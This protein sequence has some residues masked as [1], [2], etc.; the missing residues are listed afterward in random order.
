MNLLNPNL[1]RLVFCWSVAIGLLTIALVQRT[2]NAE[3][4]VDDS[5]TSKTRPNIILVMTD[6]QG[7]GDLSCHG[8]PFLKTPHI[9]KL[10]SQST[11]FTDFHVS[12]T[13][14]P[15]RAALMS[16]KAP[17]KVGV[18]H[19]VV[20]RE[21][22]TLETTTIADVLRSAGYA[23]G[24][25]GK[26]HLG[27]ADPYQPDRRG[28]D[29][30]F[31]HG[32]GGIGQSHAGD[33]SDAPGTNYF[34]PIIKHNG[35]FEQTRGY[36]TD[37]FF[38][39][40]LGW[41]QSK[42]KSS[43]AE[44]PETD[45]PFFAYISTNAPHSPYRVDPSYSDLFKE[46]CDPQQAAFLGMIVNIDENVGLLME[47]L[48]QWNL[49]DNTLLIF[50]TDN[51]SAAGSPIHNAGMKGGKGSMN[52][53]GS[54][55]PLF[56][57]LPGVTKPGVEIDRMT[58]HFD[59]FPTLAEIAGAKIPA[60]LDLDGRSLVP[61]IENPRSQ[62][63]PRNTFFHVGRWAK[64]GAPERFSKGDPN[65]DNSKYK[66]FAVRNE[67]WR[68]VNERLF[69]IVDDP[70]EATDIAAKHPEVVESLRTSFD[71]WWDQV[72][73]LMVNENAPLDVPRSFEVQFERQRNSVGIPQWIA[74]DLEGRN[75]R[76]AWW[77]EAKFGM[78]V[79]W[80]IYSTTGGEYKGQKLPNS[81]EWMMARGK[82]PIAEYE[83]YAAQFN[84][85]GFDASEFV[86][87]AK[88]AGMKYIVITAKHHDGFAMFGSDCSEFDVVDATPFKRD[89][90]KEL[91]DEC[92]KQNIKFGFYYSQAQDWH[93]PG[94]HG[95]SWDKS[96]QRVSTD[97]Y[98]RDK[99]VPEVRQLLTDYGPI[100]IFWWDTPRKMSQE[101]FDAL[102][103]LTKLQPSVITNDRLG[104]GYRG[105]Y[106][107][108]ERN[109]P[110]QAPVGEDWEVCMPISG[111]WGY[112]KGDNDFKSAQKLIRNLI[113][114]A[115]KG[116]NY[117]LNVSPTGDGTL[118]PP[119]IQR[120][121]TIGQWMDV[122]GE[123]IYATV[124][125]P[126]PQLDWGRCTAKI[127]DGQTTLY[128][129][130]FDW[131][132]DGKLI[133]P[134]LTQKLLSARLLDGKHDVA[135]AVTDAGLEL[136]LTG[137]APDPNASVIKLTIDGELMVKVQLPTPD[138]SGKLVLTADTAYV[139]NNE[140][141]KQADVRH[142]DDIPH[143]GYWLDNHAWVDWNIQ[144]DQPGTYEVHATMSVQ[145]EETRFFF[146]SE[147]NMKA[148]KVSST[149]SYGKYEQNRLGAI[150]IDQA[151]RLNLIIKPDPENWQPM[152]L[153]Q[154][155][156]QR[157]D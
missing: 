138:A 45:Q 142:H 76:L 137:E 71:A 57:R 125:S 54:R 134:G 13:C 118:L 122:N 67:Q 39:Q 77:R 102:H 150:T 72:R 66:G 4:P 75:E 3:S 114:I 133:V 18:T 92:Q 1:G 129:H 27:D 115:S 144:I 14:S 33:Q 51:G 100:G 111:S 61:L 98:V 99:A 84:P 79:H 94:G 12:A 19:T 121:Q 135:S 132:E 147:G 30:V 108:F 56:M 153:R 38:Q 112:K 123:S 90:M 52:E 73:P 29:E 124:A 9:D 145:N 148:A 103:S 93:H 89:I 136:T 20:E 85:E 117:L 42:A 155:T 21:R 62:W 25:F 47:K 15:T 106:K 116:G 74:P 126:L 91:A 31:I 80:G 96:F 10:Y 82:I 63:P 26:W 24:I 95:N 69:N 59:L 104:E 32:A 58:R 68:L 34:D 131:P 6:D 119:A 5:S 141:S 64:A 81:A 128:L 78:F 48:D 143:I 65:P 87:R 88:E 113:D 156:L 83:K 43:E 36:C 139:H 28:F 86:G 105:D 154:V 23:T 101:S 53:G 60:G 70:S 140:G 22:L 151:G 35:R 146:G 40:A 107:T 110:Q 130:V 50:M 109:I 55:V 17:F 37:V 120:L 8:H 152:N 11:R 7:Y 97:D 157:I 44:G 49:A 149:G 41:I 127:R 2:A 46:K 16:G